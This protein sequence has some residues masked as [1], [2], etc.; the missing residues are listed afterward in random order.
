[1]NWYYNSNKEQLTYFIEVY[2][3]KPVRLRIVVE[4]LI[5]KN[6][7]K[8]RPY[9]Q[10]TNRAADVTGYDK[11][12]IRMPLSPVWSLISVYDERTGNTKNDPNLKVTLHK[13]DFKKKI[14]DIYRARIEVREFIRFAEWFCEK[15][16]ILSAGKSVY[17]SPDNRFRIEYVDDIRD[18][19]GKVLSTPARIGADDGI[20]E[21][22]ANQFRKF[23]IPRRMAVLLHEYAHVYINTSPDKETEADLNALFIYLGLGYPRIEAYYTFTRVFGRSGNEHNKAEYIKRYKLIEEFIDNFDT[24]FENIK[25]NYY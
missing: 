22:S 4:D 20:I 12:Y 24:R 6:P 21:I 18:E 17:L 9:T 5:S 15:A 16:G 3:K 7:V 25:L 11:F 13:V 10:Y 1:M 23:S 19:Y 8:V 14:T 2:A